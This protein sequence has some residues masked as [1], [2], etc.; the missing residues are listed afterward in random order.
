M[1]KNIKIIFTLF[2]SHD[3]ILCYKSDKEHKNTLPQL[4]IFSMLKFF[5]VK[6]GIAGTDI[7]SSIS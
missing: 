4:F 2:L 1:P 3:V 6:I 5:P 7:Q